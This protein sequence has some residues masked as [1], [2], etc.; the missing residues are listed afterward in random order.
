MGFWDILLIGIGLSMDAVAVSVSDALAYPC[1]GRGRRLAIPAAFGLFQGLM[2][3]LGFFAGSLFADLINRYAGIVTLVTLMDNLGGT[4]LVVDAITAV[5]PSTVAPLVLLM[6]AGLASFYATSSAVIVAFAPMAIQLM[7]TIGSTNVAGMLAALVIAS[8]MVDCSP[9]AINGAALVANVQ[10][11]DKQVFFKKL[12][13]VG[14]VM[15]P[16]GSILG[17]LLFYVLGL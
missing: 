6:L 11:E 17:W 9:L 12:M 14:L 4:D 16:I 1:M 7:E 3:V 15:V 8:T 2:P 10:A 5:V 13:V